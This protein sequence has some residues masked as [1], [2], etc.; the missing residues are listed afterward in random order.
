M[1]DDPSSAPVVQTRLL[2]NQRFRRVHVKSARY[3][4]LGV[5]TKNA[6]QGIR[7]NTCSRNFERSNSEN[8]EVP[9]LT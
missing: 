4:I 2:T 1:K 7:I 8:K 9:R 6:D 3:L 5:I